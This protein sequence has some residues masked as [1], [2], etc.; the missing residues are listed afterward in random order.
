MTKTELIKLDGTLIKSDGSQVKS[1]YFKFLELLPD[2]YSDITY[3]PEEALKVRAHMSHLSTGSSAAIPLTC[4]GLAKCPFQER[5][6]FVRIDKERRKLDKTSKLVTPIGRQCLVEINLLNEWTRLYIMEFEV[7][8][9]SFFEMRTANE[10][11]EIELMLWRLNNNLAKPEYAE[12][13]QETVVG[14]DKEGNALTRKEV[15]AFVEAKDKFNNRKSRLIK[16]MVGDREGDY[17][18][19]AALRLKDEGDPSTTS[20]QLKGQITRLLREAEKGVLAL[21]EA[22]GDVIEVDGEKTA[23][24]T[25]GAVTPED[26][27]GE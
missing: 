25:P 21:K 2:D 22:E 8:E 4:A 13:V 14:V 10:L 3:T 12:L 16:H 18:R 27:I 5:C 24:S 9:T 23:Q 26:L 6:P 7:D 11:A 19:K 17:K 15:N 1:N 20:A